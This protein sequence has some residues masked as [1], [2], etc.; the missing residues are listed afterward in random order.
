MFEFG[1]NEAVMRPA[2]C[3]F[4]KSKVIDTLAKV[5]TESTVW[6][7]RRCDATWTVASLAARRLS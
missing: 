5:H 7:C 2:A 3:P 4:C 1:V 6:R